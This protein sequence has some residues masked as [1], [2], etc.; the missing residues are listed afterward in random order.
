MQ[1]IIEGNNPASRWVDVNCGQLHYKGQKKKP[2]D[3]SPG[4]AD[5]HVLALS[6]QPAFCE[7]YGYQNG[8]PECLT[9]PA[10]SYQAQ[11]MVLHGLWPNQRSCGINYGYCGREKNPDIAAIHRLF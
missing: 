5:S 8:K 1:L 7:T 2:C 3:T 9:L 11:H 10:D 6:W 4:L